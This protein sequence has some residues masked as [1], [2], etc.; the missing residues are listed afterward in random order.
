MPPP[1]KVFRVF[2]VDSLQERDMASNR[3]N[4]NVFDIVSDGFGSS[5]I[6]MVWRTVVVLG[7]WGWLSLW[8]GGRF[9]PFLFSGV[10]WEPG[11]L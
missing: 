2:K 8:R 10:G 9:L 1:R 11:F 6:V 3:W 7:S 5:L 4:V